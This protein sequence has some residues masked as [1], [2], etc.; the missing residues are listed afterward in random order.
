MSPRK[1]PGTRMRLRRAKH[2]NPQIPTLADLR[3][4][5]GKQPFISASAARI[6]AA[7]LATQGRH[8]KPYPCRH[9]NRW[10]LTSVRP[11]TTGAD[12]PSTP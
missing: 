12:A 2:P 4:Q 5:S 3:C 8:V 7:H 1:S 11:R 9:C 6:A 10:H